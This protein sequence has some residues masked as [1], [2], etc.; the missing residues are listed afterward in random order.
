MSNWLFIGKKMRCCANRSGDKRATPTLKT[1]ARRW[2]KSQN[3]TRLIVSVSNDQIKNLVTMARSI[4]AT[5]H[6]GSACEG[7]SDA[8]APVNSLAQGENVLRQPVFFQ[9]PIEHPSRPWQPIPPALTEESTVD[10]LIA[11]RHVQIPQHVLCDALTHLRLTAEAHVGMRDCAEV[12]ALVLT[13][14]VKRGALVVLS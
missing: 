13:S 1:L 11:D 9:S 5:V 2:L 10:V 6:T 14:L 12:V 7:L 3:E 8:G 4:G